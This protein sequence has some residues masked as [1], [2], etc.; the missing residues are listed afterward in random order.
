MED[1]VQNQVIETEQSTELGF[2]SKFI[3]IFIN[4]LK[5]FESLNRRPTWL[6]P[7]LIVL[8]VVAIS[9]QI[10]YTIQ[11]DAQFEALKNNSNM[12]SE[13]L[14]TQM[15]WVED[16]PVLHRVIT[17]GAALF[18]VTVVYYFILSL[19]FYFV[20]SVILGGDCTY[21]K[22]LSL[23]SWTALIGIA[24]TIVTVPLILAK[25]SI[26]KLS[27]ALLL[28]SDAL[29]S[30]LYVLLSQFNFF[31]IWQLAVLAYGFALIYKFSQAKGF[32][33]IGALWGLWIM[34]STIFAQ[35]MKNLGIM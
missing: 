5:T 6:I 23:W 27:P 21:K 24:E 31:T 29:D 30:T 17:S 9:V 33:A 18:F 2:W 25:G 22:V 12:S 32:I 10:T 14:N 11:I 4:P 28:S 16:N 34:I 15:Q 3:N 13:Q 35:T 26:V 20:G 8:A 7:M 19:I 1:Q